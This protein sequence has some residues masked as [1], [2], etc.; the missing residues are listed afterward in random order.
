MAR[1]QNQPG[2]CG[3]RRKTI[4]LAVPVAGAGDVNGDGLADIIIGASLAHANDNGAA[5]VFHG[6][7]ENPST[8]PYQPFESNNPGAFF[9]TSVSG[10]GDINGDG[11][12]DFVVGAPDF[13][14][15]DFGGGAIFVIWRSTRA[16][17]PASYFS[18]DRGS[19]G[20][21]F[22]YSVAGARDVNGD[23]YDDVIVGAYA[24]AVG[25]ITPGAVFLYA[26][27]AAGLSWPFPVWQVEG[28]ADKDMFGW[29]VAGVGDVNGDG[30]AD[31]AVGAPSDERGAY[32]FFTGRLLVRLA[33]PPQS[34]R[35]A[36]GM[37]NWGTR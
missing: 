5:Y 4:T 8:S 13:D 36:A 25:E 27:T 12:A 30:F 17:H 16:A 33:M 9:G 7:A 35:A 37:A 3:A 2:Y 29:S 19:E 15:G 31:L 6:A 18:L 21:K 26:G 34:S 22:G 10:A 20:F 11:F 23:G 24:Y 32:L 14:G 1:R 28:A